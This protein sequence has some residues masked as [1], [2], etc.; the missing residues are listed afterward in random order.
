M[1]IIKIKAIAI[2]I[3]IA[4]AVAYF[5]FQIAILTP[6][7]LCI[8]RKYSLLV[9]ASLYQQQRKSFE[10]LKKKANKKT[11]R[12]THKIGNYTQKIGECT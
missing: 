4:I 5:T 6:R 2:A 9:L 8:I 10:I 12:W 11:C 7:E 3:A 1:E